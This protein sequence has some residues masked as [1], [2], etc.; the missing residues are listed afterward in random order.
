VSDQDQEPDRATAPWPSP[1]D[2]VVEFGSGRRVRGRSLRSSVA[3][4]ALPTFA[5]HLAA[6]PPPEPSWER[7]WIRW[8]DFWVPSD[9]WTA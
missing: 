1:A 8:F 7:R 9:F 6:W 4:G 5:V 3:R 2:G